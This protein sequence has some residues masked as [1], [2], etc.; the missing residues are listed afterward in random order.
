[1]RSA[2][3]IPFFLW[4]YGVAWRTVTPFLRVS[5]R[6]REG[7]EERVLKRGPRNHVDVWIQAA[8]VGESFLALEIVSGFGPDDIPRMLI[9]TNTSQGAHIL[10]E[11]LD[12]IGG[13]RKR[14]VETA[15]FPFDAPSLMQEALK[16]WR[17]ALMV[18]LETEFWPGL[19]A[20]CKRWSVPLLVL[21]GRLSQ[22]SFKAYSRFRGFLRRLGPEEI[23]AISPVDGERFSSLFGKDRVKLMHNIKFDRMDFDSI[24]PAA[25]D[26]LRKI[27]PERI[28]FL[29][30]GSVR[31]EEE[32]DVMHTM[33]GVFSRIP[34]TI[35]ALFPRHS[36]RIESWKGRLSGSGLN[37][38]LRSRV[39][40]PVSPG[41]VLLWD[42][43]GELSS[44]YALAHA[45]FV[46]GSLRPCGGQNFLEAI[47][48][49]VR[50]CIGPY[51]ENFSWVG[52]EI[53]NTGLVR[54]VKDWRELVDVLVKDIESPGERD[55]IIRRAGVYMTRRKGGTETAC[56]AIAA[57]L[58]KT[59]NTQE[60]PS[61]S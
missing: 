3:V 14:S 27:I 21:N 40:N 9:T 11:G 17:P 15:Y 57:F 30:L 16:V 42:T 44:A 54:E 34:R 38:V 8:S 41:T 47:G 58:R 43:F 45:V 18:L 55:A 24:G 61:L 39:A 25:S 60:I 29:V 46:G 13:E 49:G 59:G 12:Q 28:P 1:M 31:R 10:H 2:D 53:L 22:R 20:A 52:R 56:R 51:W 48:Q 23:Y 6:L 7:Y 33:E 35:T 50:P 19:M 26:H 37:W 4:V 36:S 32:N 5:P